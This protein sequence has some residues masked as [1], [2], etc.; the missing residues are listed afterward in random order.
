MRAHIINSLYT[1]LTA[2]I[3]GALLT[4]GISART[5]VL[6]Y[7]PSGYVTGATLTDFSGGFSFPKFNTALG[8]LNLVT[9]ELG[10][11]YDSQLTV[12]TATPAYGAT[13]TELQSILTVGSPFISGSTLSTTS[14]HSYLNNLTPSFTYGTVSTPLTGSTT[15][16]LYTGSNSDITSTS[17]SIVIGDFSG[18]GNIDLNYETYTTTLTSDTGGTVSVFQTSHADLDAIVTYNYTPATPPPSGTPE[19]GVVALLGGLGTAGLAIARRRRLAR[20]PLP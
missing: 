17:N 3:A 2:L 8:T 7:G 6:V 11:A 18:A 16:P 13:Q 5:Q 9:I 15:S 19:P 20:K 14:F 1:T 4:T 10:N 12:S